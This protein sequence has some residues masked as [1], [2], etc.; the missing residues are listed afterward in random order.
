MD[1]SIIMAEM[2]RT[3]DLTSVIRPFRKA[4]FEGK[5]NYMIRESQTAEPTMKWR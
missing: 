4:I 3:A 5:S 2:E 1:T